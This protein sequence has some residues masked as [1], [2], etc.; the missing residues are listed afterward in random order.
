MAQERW[1]EAAPAW[2]WLP[3]DLRSRGA[4]RHVF[5]LVGSEGQGGIAEG[6]LMQGAK[7][8]IGSWGVGK[9]SRL[10]W[11]GWFGKFV[12][13]LAHL[14]LVGKILEGLMQIAILL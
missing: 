9:K 5:G 4:T 10:E 13:G 1:C 14:F 8:E 7:G 6:N 12:T 3:G 11:S 2:A